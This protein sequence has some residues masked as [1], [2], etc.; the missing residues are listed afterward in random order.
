MKE[1][2][3]SCKGNRYLKLSQLTNLQ[4]NLK[5]LSKIN[6][7]KLK[8]S[9][10][11]YGFSFP[12]FVW[13]NEDKN[14]IIDAHQRKAVLEKMQSDGYIIPEL[15]IVDIEADDKK[16]AKE[17][18][19]ML[20][21]TYGEITNDGLYEFIETAEINFDDIKDDLE[22]NIDLNMFDLEYNKEVDIIDEDIKYYEQTHILLSFPPEK[23]IEIEKELQK[24]KE[25]SWMEYEQGSN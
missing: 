20:N 9:I 8:R 25:K 12:V 5:E 19:L 1:I 23:I 18:L 17:K 11:K 22:L 24:I 15:P 7:D 21:S 2:A 14:Y 13:E 3:V 16:Q 10:L 4:G 6:A